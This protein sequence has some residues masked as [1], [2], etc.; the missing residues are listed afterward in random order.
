MNTLHTETFTVDGMS[1]QHCVRT[2]TQAIQA[3]DAQAQVQIDLTTHRV[4][5][6]STLPRADLAALIHAEG[7][8]VV[9]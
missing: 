4:V 2:I 9:D 6:S 3:R 8:T 7:Y 1:C 5:V